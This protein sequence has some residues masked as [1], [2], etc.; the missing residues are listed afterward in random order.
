V[1]DL[2]HDADA[3]VISAGREPR[4]RP[5]RPGRLL[6]LVLI[7]ESVLLAGSVAAALH[8]RGEVSRLRHR[9]PAASQAGPLP[10][11]TSLTVRLPPDG[12]IAGTVLITAAAQPGARRGQF[13]VSATITGGHPGTVYNLTGNDCSAEAPLPDHVWATGV[14]DA[15][16]A[17]E[18]TGHAWTGLIA[19]AYWLAL[20][21]SPDRPP[22]GLR[23]TFLQGMATRFPASQAPCGLP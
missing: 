11:M 9:G 14:T 1:P 23:G 13:A 17:A 12:T 21:P 2:P 18:L 10:Q 19:D 5:L 20:S 6:R 7:A 15:A 8:Y 16:G 22:P 3:D 4:A